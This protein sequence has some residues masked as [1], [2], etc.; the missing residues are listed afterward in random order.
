MPRGGQACYFWGMN[1][2]D[3][4]HCKSFADLPLPRAGGVVYVVKEGQDGGL[5]TFLASK[6]F[7]VDTL[8]VSAATLDDYCG[9]TVRQLPVATR[10]TV[11]VGGFAAMEV[12]K[13]LAHKHGLPLWCVPTDYTAA[14]ALWCHTLWTVG[15]TPTFVG[16]DGHTTLVVDNLLSATRDGTQQVYQ[17]LFAYYAAAVDD[18][19]RNRMCGT[20]QANVGLRQAAQTAHT[21]LSAV[22]EYTDEAGKTLWTALETCA[23]VTD[24]KETE[25][26]SLAICVYKKGNMSYNRYTFAAAYAR[27][28]ALSE[29]RDLPDLYLPPDR[30][31]VQ[32]TTRALGWETLPSAPTEDLRRLDWVWRDYLPDL[33]T[34]FADAGRMARCWRRLAGDAGYGYF[35]DLTAA[36][37]VA[38][39]PVVADMS[40]TYS[41]F[42]HLYL[43][44]GF[45][46]FV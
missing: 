25:L 36:E 26:L 3:I 21:A 8:V 11:A 27:A 24:T 32:E 35:E 2:P 29:H 15:K 43:R 38:L 18:V 45:N 10:L 4:L 19:C 34:A 14:S 31:A 5:V 41:P 44:G 6:G 30:C 1:A 12:G 40:P 46:L 13:L 7:E 39:L 28:V 20:E 23:G 33:Q 9:V 16:T 22:D 37:V 17:H 42:R